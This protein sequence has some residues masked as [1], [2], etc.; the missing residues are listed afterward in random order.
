[1][2]AYIHLLRVV[3]VHCFGPVRHNLPSS[4]RRLVNLADFYCLVWLAWGVYFPAKLYSPNTRW[5]GRPLPLL[6]VPPII[7]EA[8]HHPK[9][10]ETNIGRT[11]FPLPWLWE[12]G[13]PFSKGCP[14]LCWPASCVGT[15]LHRWKS[16]G[17]S[18]HVFGHPALRIIRNMK[19]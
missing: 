8:E 10:K 1:M 14:F 5:L 16:K 6:H 2:E 4:G 3:N 15:L 7:M 19:S 18:L 11:H 13:Y 17:W 9:W 12:E